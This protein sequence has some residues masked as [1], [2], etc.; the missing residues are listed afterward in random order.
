MPPLALT[1]AQLD[2]IHRLS[3]PLA[4]RDR[5]AFLAL[6]AQRLQ[7]HG[8]DIGDGALYPRRATSR[9]LASQV[10]NIFGGRTGQRLRVDN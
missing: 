2:V 9:H 8:G 4:P 5:S 3:W 1:D 6:V 10:A 7:Q